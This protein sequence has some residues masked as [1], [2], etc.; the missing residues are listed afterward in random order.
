MKPP[1]NEAHRSRL[2]RLLT[3]AASYKLAHLIV[4]FLGRRAV[5]RQ[6]TANQHT[7]SRIIEQK[8]IGHKKLRMDKSKQGSA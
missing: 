8:S 5:S 6:Q 7:I 1:R 3:S 4:L 2:M